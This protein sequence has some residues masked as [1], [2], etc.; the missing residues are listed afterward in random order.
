V[1]DRADDALQDVKRDEDNA[2]PL[3]SRR[4]GQHR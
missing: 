3:F 2:E 4:N 1:D